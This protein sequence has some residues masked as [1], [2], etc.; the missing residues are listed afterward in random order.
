MM[1]ITE[2]NLGLIIFVGLDMMM[3]I[4]I[5]TSSQTFTLLPFNK[6]KMANIPYR[7]HITWP[8]HHEMSRRRR[9]KTLEKGEK[10][11]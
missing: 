2:K 5:W 10:I 1:M 7:F 11:I 8:Y 6:I 9:K 4:D 3:V